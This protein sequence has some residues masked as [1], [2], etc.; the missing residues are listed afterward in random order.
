MWQFIGKSLIN[1]WIEL[2]CIN[3]NV[4]ENVKMKVTFKVLCICVLLNTCVTFDLFVNNTAADD[5]TKNDTSNDK[6]GKR[7]RLFYTLS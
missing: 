3:Y 6:N 5:G 2:K 4:N 7:T 1:D